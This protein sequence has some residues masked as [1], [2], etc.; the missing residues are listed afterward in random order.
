MVTGQDN[1]AKGAQKSLTPTGAMTYSVRGLTY[2]LSAI[3]KEKYGAN[4]R[5][6]S[7]A[8]RQFN[9]CLRSPKYWTKTNS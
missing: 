7:L 4:S 3:A 9:M 6:S 5:I 8:V 2:S 1:Y